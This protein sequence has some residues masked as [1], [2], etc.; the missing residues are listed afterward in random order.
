M[1]KQKLRRYPTT[2]LLLFEKIFNFVKKAFFLFILAVAAGFFKLTKHFFLLLVEVLGCFNDYVYIHIALAP[3]VYRLDALTLEADY[4]ARLCAFGKIK[5][6]LALQCGDDYLIAQC[7]LNKGD[8]HINDNIIA[9]TP[10]DFVGL[11][12]N[13]HINITRITTAETAIA[14]TANRNSLSVVDACGDLDLQL[15]ALAYR[16]VAVTLI[17]GLL[18]DLSGTSAVA[19]GG[20]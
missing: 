3:A 10:E 8:G 4:S 11:D 7:C 17:A 2:E 18:D 15:A 6:E 13:G 19:A 20:G 5:L 9:V 14:L 1:K 16:A 12:G